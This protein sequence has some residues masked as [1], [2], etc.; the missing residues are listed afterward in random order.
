MFQVVLETIIYL[1]VCEVSELLAQAAKG[2]R[3]A[4]VLP[5]CLFCLA[6][7]E[8]FEVSQI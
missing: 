3:F 7:L 4:Y 2:T 6:V 5:S 1:M 8:E